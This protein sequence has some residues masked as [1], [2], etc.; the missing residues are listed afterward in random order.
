MTRSD[1]TDALAS[2]VD[3][4]KNKAKEVIK[5]ILKTMANA[6]VCGEGTRN[7]GIRLIEF[8]REIAPHCNCVFS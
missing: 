8:E 5:T 6:L 3:V 2:E 4:S 7:M 1:L